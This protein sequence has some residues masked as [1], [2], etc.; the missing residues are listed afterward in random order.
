MQCCTK[1][2][3]LCQHSTACSCPTQFITLQDPFFAQ[4]LYTMCCVWEK[5]R[6][7]PHHTTKNFWKVLA[8]RYFLFRCISAC[9][10]SLEKSP[11]TWLASM[12]MIRSLAFSLR[13]V[14]NSSGLGLQIACRGQTCHKQNPLQVTHVT[15]GAH[16]RTHTHTHI[17]TRAHTRTHTP[18]HT[19]T[20][21]HPPTHTHTYTGL[22]VP[23]S[24]RAAKP[25]R[26]PRT[27]TFGRT[28]SLRIWA[29]L[30]RSTSCRP[31]SS[32]A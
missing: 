5:D 13:K 26:T 23:K 11:S 31:C 22:W 9:Q 1:K 16:A 21:P 4:T 2:L 15:A 6:C 3:V 32:W 17:H 20:H 8:F 25:L 18:T 30:A 29:P 27:K 24:L 14:S 7:M 12:S 10:I 19:H 28:P